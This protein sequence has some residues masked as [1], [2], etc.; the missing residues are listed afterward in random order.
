MDSRDSAVSTCSNARLR[1]IDPLS[2][3][4]VTRIEDKLR[5]GSLADLSDSGGD[6]RTPPVI[7]GE[8]LAGSSKGFIRWAVRAFKTAGW[9]PGAQLAH[10]ATS[11]LGASV[12][13]ATTYG[14]GKAT[15]AWMQ[16]G[17]EMTGE[18]LRQVFDAAAFA[19]Q[20]HH[21]GTEDPDADAIEVEVVEE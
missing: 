12:A 10:L 6:P 4:S 19:Y 20:Q 18:Q 7:L 2:A 21:A 9:I 16:S 3:A 15:V 5:S 11:A 17:P 13:G 8:V 14:V 1:G